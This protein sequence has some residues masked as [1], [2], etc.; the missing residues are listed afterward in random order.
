[1]SQWPTKEPKPPK[2]QFLAY[3]SKSIRQM[4]VLFIYTLAGSYRPT[5]FLSLIFPILG[6]SSSQMIQ[7]LINPWSCCSPRWSCGT[8]STSYALVRSWAHNLQSW[9][10]Q[11]PGGLCCCGRMGR[12]GPIEQRLLGWAC[13]GNRGLGCSEH[14]SGAHSLGLLLCILDQ[15]RCN[16]A[17]SRLPKSK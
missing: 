13:C 10:W 4:K 17:R 9:S 8:T 6:H 2:P 14:T 12:P 15:S 7:H 5:H 11:P 3:F 1:M 16:I